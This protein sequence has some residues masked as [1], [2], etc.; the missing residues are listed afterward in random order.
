MSKSHFITENTL[1]TA[2]HPGKLQHERGTHLPLPRPPKWLA[3]ATPPPKRFSHA[4]ARRSN[5]ARAFHPHPRPSSSPQPSWKWSRD[6]CHR[7][8]REASSWCPPL[9]AVSKFVPPSIFSARS[10]GV[11][12]ATS[13]THPQSIALPRPPELESV[14]SGTLYNRNFNNNSPLF[15][16]SFLTCLSHKK[17]NYSRLLPL[18]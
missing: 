11:Y 13:A 12:S 7:G 16:S 15:Y 4:S 3:S 14:D 5:L 10:D 8:P 6:C 2:N 17:Q 9:P 18:D 1:Y